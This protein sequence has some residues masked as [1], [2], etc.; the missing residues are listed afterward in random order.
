MDFTATNVRQAA[1][2][3][4]LRFPTHVHDQVVAALDSGKH[5]ILTGPPGTGKTTLA[6]VASEVGRQAMLCTGYLPTTASS[7]WTTYETIGGLQ[8]TQ[9]GLIF[10]PGLFLESIMNGSWLIIDELNRANFDRAFGPLFT[11]LSG[12]PVVLPYKRI[13]HTEPV[14]LVPYGSQP[15]AHT[16]VIRVPNSWRIIATMNVMD[17]NLLFD[18]SYALMRRFAFIEV[19]CPD[20]EVY[21]SLLT[22][23]GTVIA[24]LLVLRR[25]TELGPAIFV[26]AARYVT[27]R[28]QDRV[29]RSR[30]LYEVFYSYFLPQFEGLDDVRAAE[31][32]R[33]LEPLLDEPERLEAQRAIREVLSIEL[34]V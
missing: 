7:E 27:R 33:L 13:G 12:S 30:V 5:I 26:D 3:E 1:E 17:K 28:A 11:V 14:S 8:P 25:L 31:L 20:D 23:P 18:M 22:G 9:E 29:S 4:G 21:R 2:G 32:Y 6:Y 16:D 34:V 19:G 24:D 10:R 15:P